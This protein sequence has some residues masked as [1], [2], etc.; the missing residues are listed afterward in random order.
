MPEPLTV[1]VVSGTTGEYSDRTEWD[2][3][4]FTSEEQAEAYRALLLKAVR[5][6]D[7]AAERAAADL[8]R[9]SLAERKQPELR[10]L[11]PQSPHRFDGIE[12]AVT[13]HRVW[14]HVDEFLESLP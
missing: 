6:R 4:V 8:W 12:Y 2:A 7:G 13:A 11:D 1:W 14:R 10:K 5:Y 9:G 3:A